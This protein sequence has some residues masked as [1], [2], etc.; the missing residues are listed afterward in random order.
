MPRCANKPIGKTG[1]P[2]LQHDALYCCCG[3]KLKTSARDA[4]TPEW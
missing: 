4:I 2:L 3:G 1:V